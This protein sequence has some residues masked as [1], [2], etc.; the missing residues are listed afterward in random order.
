MDTY[1]ASECNQT[2]EPPVWTVAVADDEPEILDYLVR[3]L[4]FLGC[5]VVARAAD[6]REL[7]E[8]CRLMRPE[9][10]VTDVR[11]PS[12][13][14]LQAIA[15][16]AREQPILAIFIS[17]QKPGALDPPVPHNCIVD[18]LVKPVRRTDIAV[19]LERA[20]QK[21]NEAAIARPT[22]VA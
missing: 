4:T 2:T 10:V 14:G 17:A 18:F 20:A 11:M 9:L 16:L 22:A 15:E 1:D 6:G 19:A 12:M 7:V 5:H 3:V 13:S 21:R 8:Q